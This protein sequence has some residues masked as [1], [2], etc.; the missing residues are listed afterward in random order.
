MA[1]LRCVF[2][3]NVIISALLNNATTPSFALKHAEDVG[4]VLISETTTQELTTV[5]A[6]PKVTRYISENTIRELVER[7]GSSWS[8]VPILYNV[9]ACSDPDDDKFLDV[10]VNGAATHLITGDRALLALDPFRNMKIL[11]PA[12]FLSNA[13]V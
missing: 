8:V 1:G 5:L 9:Q 3:T 11:T 10:A 12:Q 2:D 13:D 6:R 7:I 4:T